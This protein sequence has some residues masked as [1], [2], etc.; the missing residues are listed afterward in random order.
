MFII[1]LIIFFVMT[2]MSVLRADYLNSEQKKRVD[3]IITKLN[4]GLATPGM[5]APYFFRKSPRDNSAD[6]KIEL[7]NVECQVTLKRFGIIPRVSQKEVIR[8]SGSVYLTDIDFDVKPKGTTCRLL[9]LSAADGY[10]LS[11]HCKDGKEC[12]SETDVTQWDKHTLLP[13]VIEQ[14]S[15]KSVGIGPFRENSNC[16]KFLEK[17]KEA[18][19]QCP[20]IQPS[21]FD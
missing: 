17:L 21:P 4:T 12:D 1:K 6:S 14:S 5:F 10:Y 20:T 19:S 16:E 15:I 8:S 11:L 18:A 7:S 13:T 3:G 9:F 2:S